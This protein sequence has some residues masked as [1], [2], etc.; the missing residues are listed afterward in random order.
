MDAKTKKKQRNN[1]AKPKNIQSFIV[2]KWKPGCQRDGLGAKMMPERYTCQNF[3][4]TS[5]LKRQ[6]VWKL[7]VEVFLNAF[8]LESLWSLRRALFFK[9][10][11]K[12]R[13][14]SHKF[15]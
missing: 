1:Y 5:H 15:I 13:N 10:K 12:I 14:G 7:F 3:N 8:C 11:M 4:R 9:K 6:R 2:R